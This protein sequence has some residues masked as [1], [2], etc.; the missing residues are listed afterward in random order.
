MLKHDERLLKKSIEY[1][2]HNPFDAVQKIL[3]K[4]ENNLFAPKTKPKK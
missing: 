2:K 1:L 3:E 4:K